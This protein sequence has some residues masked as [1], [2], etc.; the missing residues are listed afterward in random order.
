M[1]QSH[2]DPIDALLRQQFEGSVADNGF[3]E[4]LMQ[5]LPPRR[6][7]MAWPLWAG[8]VTGT[9]VCWLSLL[10]TPLLHIGWQDWMHGELSASA[11]TLLL[12]IAILSLLACGWAT[13][14]A[15]DH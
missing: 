15:D 12:T 1:N 8:V 6:R 3:S 13:M 14:E 11:I 4:R 7:R 10:S 5:R 2:D 9:V